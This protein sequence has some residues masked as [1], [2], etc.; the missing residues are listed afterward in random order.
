MDTPVKYRVILADPPWEFDHRGT[1]LDPSY[2]G[3]QRK[4]K[5]YNVLGLDFIKYLGM[6]LSKIVEK[7]AFLFLWAP[8]SFVLDGQAQEIISAW[9]FT[10]KQL[11]TWVK[12]DSK[13]KPRMGGG[14]YTRTCTEQLILCRKGKAKRLSASI[15]G[16]LI[17]QRGAHSAKP[18]EQ[19]KLIET[20]CAGPYLELFARKQSP[21]WHVWGNELANSIDLASL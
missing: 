5:H 13:G 21:G 2:K 9:G 6:P 12:V 1:R 17:T 4:T 3:K 15:P 18:T 11:I 8:N 7:D 14:S 16:V 19:Y 20:L 10:P